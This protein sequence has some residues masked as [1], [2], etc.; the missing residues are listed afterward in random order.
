M[1]QGFSI[2]V[3]PGD[4][5]CLFRSVAYLIYGDEERHMEVRGKCYDYMDANQEFFSMS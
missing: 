4:G 2:R 1:I 3:V 5:N